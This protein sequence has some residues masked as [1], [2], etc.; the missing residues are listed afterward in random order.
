MLYKWSRDF[1]KPA[2]KA[3]KRSKRERTNGI[4]LQLEFR[5][6][7]ALSLLQSDGSA[8]LR[9]VAVSVAFTRHSVR[10]ILC[11]GPKGRCESGTGSA[12][13]FTLK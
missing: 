8:P 2:Y 6:H 10:C 3:G 12:S 1:R 9:A 13:T 4:L 7:I 5:R 11:T